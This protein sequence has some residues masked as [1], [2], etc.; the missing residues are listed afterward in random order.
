LSAAVESVSK[1]F[2]NVSEFC[3]V[4]D[5]HTLR[6]A[7]RSTLR[8][9]HLPGSSIIPANLKLHK[10]MESADEKYFRDSNAGRSRCLVC[11]R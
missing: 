7:M 9:R 3:V 2:E 6:P 8:Y 4:V 5:Y 1:D 10:F 11:T